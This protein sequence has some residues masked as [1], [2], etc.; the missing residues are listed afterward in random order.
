[1][2][3]RATNTFLLAEERGRGPVRHSCHPEPKPKDLAAERDVTYDRSPDPS[4]RCASFRMTRNSDASFRMT[5]EGGV[6]LWVTKEDG[7]SLRVTGG[8][9]DE[10]GL[11]Q[12]D[13]NAN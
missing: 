6:S 3:P 9:T 4:L 10:R 13:L 12:Y 7:V 8:R 11:P 2:R 5:K 1:M